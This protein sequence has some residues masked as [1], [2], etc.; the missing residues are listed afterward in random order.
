[1]SQTKK[2]F[3]V[4]GWGGTNRLHWQQWIVSETK[5]QSGIKAELVKMPDP[6]FPKPEEWIKTLTKSVSNPSSSV[7]LAGHSLGVPTILRYLEK[8][9]AGKKVGK[10]ILVAGFC[11]SIGIP[12]IDP[13]VQKEFDWKKI[14]NSAEKIIVVYSDNDPYIPL[15]E[16]LFLAERLKVEPIVEKNGGHITAPDFGPYPK[17]LEWIIQE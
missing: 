1:M 7:C 9:P 3:L 4:H 2:I 11:R 13:F 10:I 8:L 17:M 12:I 6:M 14:K 15:L 16:S 5:K